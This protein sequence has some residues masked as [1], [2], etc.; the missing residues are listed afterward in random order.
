MDYSF[1]RYLAAKRS[2]DDR[3]LN[4]AVWQA[5]AR[6]L[7]DNLNCRVLEAGAGTGVMF[8]RMVEWGALQRADYLAVDASAENIA[9]ARQTL[10]DWARAHGLGWDEAEAGRA[11]VF[12]SDHHHL[13]LEFETADI[14]AFISREAGW[15][16]WDLLMAHAFID[17]FDPRDLLPRLA[18]LVRPEGRMYLTINF[19]GETIFEPVWDAELEA[20]IISAYHRSMDERVTDGRPSGDSR[21]GRHLFQVLAENGLEILEAGSSDWVVFP[22]QGSYPADEA[23]FLHHI[24]HFFEETIA[25]RPEIDQARFL[26][27]VQRRHAQVERGE[28][29]YL[30]HQFDFLARKP[31]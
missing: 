9:A 25:T 12:T 27:W 2:V 8:Q 3:A 1:S 15:H 20:Q 6:F 4:R 10:P 13:R 7:G 11:L 21:A 5:T 24:L 18:R 28:L 16:D 31:F 23:Y 29:V 19:D 26:D 17:L 30:A 14:Y 22:R